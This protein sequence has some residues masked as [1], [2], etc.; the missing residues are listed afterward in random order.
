[1]LIR[2]HHLAIFVFVEM[3][4]PPANALQEHAAHCNLRS[5]CPALQCS[6]LARQKFSIIQALRSD[7]GS[8]MA[9]YLPSGE[10]M[11]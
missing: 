6:G 1:M 3:N 9:R 8:R 10:A 5:S 4:A 11:A 2:V 7:T